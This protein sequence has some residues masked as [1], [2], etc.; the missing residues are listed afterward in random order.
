MSL[1]SSGK[2]PLRALL[3]LLVGSTIAIFLMIWQAWV[4]IIQMEAANV[5]Q[6]TLLGLKGEILYNTEKMMTH[7]RLYTRTM[8]P[9]WLERYK[10]NKAALE[11]NL[12]EIYHMTPQAI[13]EFGEEI[14]SNKD[15]LNELENASF[16]LMQ[17]RF[18]NEGLDLLSGA[19]Y[20]A[21]RDDLTHNLIQLSGRLTEINEGE[22]D[23]ARKKIYWQCG[24]VI[25]VLI[26]LLGVWIFCLRLLVSWREKLL[27]ETEQRSNVEIRFSAQ[28]Q[29]LDKIIENLPVGL[30]VKNVQS[31][32]RWDIWN[33]K[34]EE[35][36][37]LPASKVI[38]TSDFDHFPEHE[39]TYF[40][41]TD[42]KVM[43][44]GRVVDI[45][46]EEITTSR[47]TWLGHTIKVPIFNDKGEPSLLMGIVEDITVRKQLA[48]AKL[49]AYAAELEQKND[50]LE[51]AR[52]HAEAAD[53]A[54]SQFLA[55][56]SHEIRTP[57]NGVLGTADLLS[58]TAL[59][60]DQDDYVRTIRKSGETL[61]YVINDILDLTKLEAKQLGLETI[62][63][64]FSRTIED[65]IDIHSA[66]ATRKELE[67]LLRYGPGTPE[68]VYGD[69]GRL[70]QI[71][72]NLI[73]NA[74]K[75]TEAGHI[76]VSVEEVP[77]QRTSTHT[78]LKVAVKDTGIGIDLKNTIK[79]F[80]RFT[81][82]EASTTRK[83][84]GT[85]LGLAIC[86][87]LVELMGGEIGLDSTP[88][89]G[90]T[91]WFTLPTTI[92]V[93]PVQPLEVADLSGKQVLVVDDNAVNVGIME[94]LLLYWGCE[95]QS[96]NSGN[97]TLNWLSGPQ[98]RKF[99][100]AI[101]DHDM[102]EMGG[103]VLCENLR[104][105]PVTAN[106][107]MMVFSS[108]GMRGDASYFQE[109]G[110]NGYLVKPSRP[111]EIRRMLQALLGQPASDRFLTK[112]Y[113][114]EQGMREECEADVSLGM[115]VLVAEDDAVNQKVVRQM[116]EEL[117]CH[118]TLAANGPVAIQMFKSGEFDLVFMDM[119]M[120]EM[121]GPKAATLI[122]QWEVE[123]LKE[124]TPIIALTANAMAEHRTLCLAAGMD[125]YMTKP[126][127]RSKLV[128]QLNAL[129]K[130][131]TQIIR[132]DVP[133]SA[134]A[135]A[136]L[137]A[138]FIASA[139]ECIEELEDSA[140]FNDDERWAR[141][142]HRLNGASVTLGYTKL[143][144]LCVQAEQIAGSSGK[145]KLFN[146]IVQ[147]MK[148]INL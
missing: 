77:S 76:L 124:R 58:R 121:D 16:M 24:L 68:R 89:E 147:E 53:K 140:L 64:D 105:H 136:E 44:E 129:N 80:E 110:F 38:G 102:P 85:G 61:L 54:K 63:F 106:I 119:Q 18:R 37:G 46:E 62:A 96:F 145:E 65:V 9:V 19:E 108:R 4:G 101:I 111:E 49:Q 104:L 71:L 90:S 132:E 134:G 93:T 144:S 79:I 72:N 127:S 50:E 40:R 13:L 17:Q 56:M 45:E 117:G 138:L 83:Y 92:D 137:Q 39:A 98:A 116:L 52:S 66:N 139:K 70:R 21:F 94:E 86:K 81:Q 41:Q 43:R 51:E 75:F 12:V 126:L 6:E 15:R 32:Y 130:K 97:E 14:E 148:R 10:A 103:D 91:F 123:N 143:S 5:R 29:I 125:D 8:Q 7:A 26:G 73:S 128:T 22:E 99:D 95:V 23:A 135:R 109:K 141:A 59:S 67:L 115:N 82:A 114:G 34:A 84:G 142:A 47:G 69:P 100:V 113:I 131:G 20:L 48:N 31:N 122:R 118:V 2:L 3:G 146:E 78:C 133:M 30:F 55:T 107:P 27:L 25:A 33:R 35:L 88:G 42:E 36:F 74:I 28:S 87:Q 60:G 120:P 1:T 11:Q 57:L 112:H